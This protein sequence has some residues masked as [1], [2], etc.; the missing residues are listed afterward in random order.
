MNLSNFHELTFAIQMTR[1]IIIHCTNSVHYL[2]H[3]I[4]LPQI[5]LIH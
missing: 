5:H 3:S 2:L 4:L 1:T